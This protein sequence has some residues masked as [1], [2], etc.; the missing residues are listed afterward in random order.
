MNLLLLAVLSW[1]PAATLEK[2]TECPSGTHRVATNNIYSPFKCVK[3]GKE[4]AKGFGAVA[5]PQGFKFRPKCPRGSRPVSSGEGALQQ[6]RCVRAAAGEEEPELSPL[7]SSHELP[8]AAS[9]DEAPADPMT[10][11]CPPG[12]RKVRTTDPLNPFQCVSQAT[13]V[14]SLGADAYR[15]WTVAGELQFE[16]PR[17][18]RPQDNWKDEVPTLVFTLD[19][20]RGGKPVT[21]TVSRIDHDQPTFQDLE[22]AIAKDKEWQG[23]SDGGTGRV[24]PAAIPARFT[25]VVGETRTAYVPIGKDRYYQ[26]VYSAPVESYELYLPAFNRM[27][28]TL[29]L[30]R[31]KR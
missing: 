21:I 31:R 27:L 25:Y 13:R 24:G 12:K 1:A 11:G 17:M 4:D 10:R 6:Y 3:D 28:K 2:T 29:A 18:F 9:A 5:G 19:E 30:L 26:L 20:D 16:Y 23:S 22:S 15:R 8:E 14:T 7:H